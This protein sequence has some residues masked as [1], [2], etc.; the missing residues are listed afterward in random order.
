M[1]KDT[2]KDALMSVLP[3]PDVEASREIGRAAVQAMLV[4]AVDSSIG[5]VID[6]NGV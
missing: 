2:I 6:C 1:A 5:A 4:I 3:V